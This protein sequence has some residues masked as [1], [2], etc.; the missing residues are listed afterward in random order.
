MN[1]RRSKL[2]IYLEVLQIIK[3]GTSKPTQIMYNANISWKPLIQALNSMISQDLIREIDVSSEIRY[4]KEAKGLGL[5]EAIIPIENPL[6]FF[7]HRSS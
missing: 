2:E 1:K 3:D 4:F 5:V 7:N 6:N